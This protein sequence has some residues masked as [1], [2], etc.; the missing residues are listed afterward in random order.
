MS[1]EIHQWLAAA[2]EAGASDLHIL[3]G[4]RPTIRLHGQLIALDGPLLDNPSVQQA[5]FAVCPE[6]ALV[7]FQSQHNVDFALQ[8]D[9][10]GSPHRF[11]TN[12][13]VSNQELGACFRFI[14][15]QIPE[16]DW[17]G[18]PKELASRLIDFRNGLVLFTGVTGSGKTTS[19]AMVIELL[20]QA[21]GQR[22]ITV[23]DPIEYL[24]PRVEDSIVTQREV[25]RDVQSFA[26][27]LRYGLRQDPD[28]ILVGEIRDRE[29]AQMA[30]SAAETGHLVFSTLHTRDCKG[31]ISRFTDLVPQNIQ[32]ELRSQL[33]M[34][35]RAVVSQHLL[36]SEEGDKREL[37]LEVMFNTNPIASAIRLGKIESIDTGIMTG[38]ADGMVSL[39]ESIRQLQDS[40]RISRETAARFL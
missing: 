39:A 10:Q 3:C 33:A 28:V 23:E 30:L 20:N 29:T 21:G 14:P 27:G 9:L 19:L 36:P 12:Y 8:I 22:I 25:G 7:R 5:L 11:R 34:S 37:A 17:A 15:D 35:L 16:F 40:G 31:A 2:V 24:F 4:H 32:T 13:Y 38:R 6:D 18:F 26:D 1:T